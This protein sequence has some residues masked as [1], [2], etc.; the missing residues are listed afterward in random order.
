MVLHLQDVTDEFPKLRSC[1]GP[2]YAL[3]AALQSLQDE[4]QILGEKAVPSGLSHFHLTE[5]LSWAAIL[6][7]LHF[8]ACCS[9]I[10]HPPN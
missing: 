6:W 10:E 3:L 1:H 8:F 9:I 2:A 4:F 7:P 5:P